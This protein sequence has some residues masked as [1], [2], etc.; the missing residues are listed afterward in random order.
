M[1]TIDINTI[2]DLQEAAKEFLV[3]FSKPG[4]FA[5]YGEMGA[6]KTTFIQS[7]CKELNVLDIVTSPTFSLVNEYKSSKNGMIYHFDF[8]RIKSV[9]EVFD[10]GY[11]EYFFQNSYCFIEWPEKIESLLPVPTIK[12][13]LKVLPGGNRRLS[14]SSSGI[15]TI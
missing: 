2:K 13:Y 6:G 11:E 8:Y 12:V 14:F 4:V 3:H 7:V 5:F 9:S 15:Q 10:L 1:I